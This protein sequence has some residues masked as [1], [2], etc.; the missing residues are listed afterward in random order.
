MTTLLLYIVI[1]NITHS[2]N[3]CESHGDND[4]FCDAHAEDGGDAE[5]DDDVITRTTAP[6]NDK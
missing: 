3:R 4:Y 1:S 6:I 5:G 2:A